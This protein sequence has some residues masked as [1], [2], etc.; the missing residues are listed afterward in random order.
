MQKDTNKKTFQANVNS[1]LWL[2][3][4]IVNY[5]LYFV[6]RMYMHFI[7][8]AGMQKDLRFFVDIKQYKSRVSGC[9]YK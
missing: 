2:V 9:E 4:Y 1:F 7:K 8:S 6:A 3:F 5:N